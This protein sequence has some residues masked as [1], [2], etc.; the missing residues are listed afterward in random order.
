MYHNK[1]LVFQYIDHVVDARQLG[2][3]YFPACIGIRLIAALLHTSC[4]IN[5]GALFKAGPGRL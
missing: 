1:I 5:L 4:Q 2:E 3:R